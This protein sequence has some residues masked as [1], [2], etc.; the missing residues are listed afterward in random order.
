ME[1]DEHTHP[2]DNPI[3]NCFTT[4]Y[5]NLVIEKET[6]SRF[7]F[8]FPPFLAMSENG[9]KDEEYTLKLVK[10]LLSIL[11]LE[12][13]FYFLGTNPLHLFQRFLGG[14]SFKNEN[15]KLEIKQ[16]LPLIQMIC[17]ESSDI[18]IS[19]PPNPSF[20]VTE[21]K[22]EEELEGMMELV[23]FVYP[24]YF[25]ARNKELGRF[26]GVIQ[27]GKVVSMA[28]ERMSI[29]MNGKTYR[30]ITTVCTH[31]Q[32]LRRGYAKALVA[33]IRTIH[34]EQ[35]FVSFMHVDAE[36][37]SAISLYSSVGFKVR[38]KVPFTQMNMSKLE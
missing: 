27:D 28:G 31:P 18:S 10:D 5:R 34:A 14:N 23:R 7:Q 16:H 11:E 19:S 21:I 38:S 32:Y 12:E 20:E 30:E 29:T 37:N 36:N 4:N 8:G 17:D 24:G 25:R 3:W 9:E 35:G 33:R 13:S 6:V 15:Y 1:K 22:S 26:F 2:L